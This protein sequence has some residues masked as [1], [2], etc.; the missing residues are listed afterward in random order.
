[1][2]VMMMTR[3]GA[4]VVMGVRDGVCVN[5]ESSFDPRIRALK[6][7]RTRR[8]TSAVAASPTADRPTRTPPPRLVLCCGSA[9]HATLTAPRASLP[10]MAAA[11]TT[12]SDPH[13]HPVRVRV[14]TFNVHMFTT[15]RTGKDNW[16][17]VRDTVRASGADVVC[18]QEVLHPHQALAV[19][20]FIQPREDSWIGG[21]L[22]IPAGSGG[23]GGGARG[24]GK[25]PAAA[26]AGRHGEDVVVA[27]AAPKVMALPELAASLGD[28]WTSVWYGDDGYGCA[29]LS[30]LPVV[31]V[32]RVP[33]CD[34]YTY[35]IRLL[36]TVGIDVPGAGLLRVNT[37]HLDHVDE[38]MR[39]E[40]FA[41]AADALV[42]P[43]VVDVGAP[44][45]PVTG[46]AGAGPVLD[47]DGT[48]PEAGDGAPKTAPA[49]SE[50]DVALLSGPAHLLCGDFN[51]LHKPD[52]SEA[53]W[54]R[55][56]AVREK[57]N[58][59]APRSALMEGIISRDGYL[60]AA[61]CR[62]GAP[63]A[64]V[65]PTCRFDTR[66]DYLLA[67]PALQDASE[68]GGGWRFVEG[69]Y[70]TVDMGASDHVLAFVDL[71]HA[72]AGTASDAAGAAAS[73]SGSSE[74]DGAGAG[75]FGSA[76]TGGAAAG[77]LALAT[78]AIPASI[79]SAVPSRPSKVTAADVEL[80]VATVDD[81]P[82]L[83]ALIND[84][85]VVES[86]FKLDKF[87][88]RTE[89]NEIRGNIMSD[90][91]Q[92][93]AAV[94]R[95]SGAVVGSGLFMPLCR[96]I[97]APEAYVG[98]IAVASEMQ[99]RGLGGLIIEGI[100]AWAREAGRT[101]INLKLVNLRAE[102]L[103]GWYGARGYVEQRR[104]PWP[105]PG[106]SKLIRPEFRD[107]IGFVHMRKEL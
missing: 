65:P 58:W 43:A 48:E 59:E 34:V 40:Q 95:A 68:V 30:R 60:D 38:S 1:M 3:R 72:G 16:A 64:P 2:M 79:G 88:K 100:E 4:V 37:T 89:K 85:F 53:Q 66:I 77:T 32:R 17:G 24:D 57:N 81:V 93:M 11:M 33:L 63:S 9:T 92:M 22:D 23:G 101:H 21:T 55:I 80:R 76:A 45:A 102:A 54:S 5:S 51:A 99:G 20:T 56:A 96:Y 39:Q 73:G 71:V 86:A 84:A 105:E 10:T 31:G 82:A 6:V 29:V 103:I 94:D 49:A 70:R 104:E 61:G 25:G 41:V 26:S 52:Y 69:S 67:S 97:E 75:E 107:T 18:M 62:P 19:S 28:D 35:G 27:A 50:G 44:P 47:G 83:V 46:Y 74:A 78:G 106:R 87:A 15:A 7:K 8:L 12:T 91:S 90:H 98:M 42:T 14:A 13:G 36:L